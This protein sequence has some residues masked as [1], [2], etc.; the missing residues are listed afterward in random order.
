MQTGRKKLSSGRMLL[1]AMAGFGIGC[2]DF[3]VAV[4][5]LI[6]HRPRR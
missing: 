6:L 5:L 3:I 4:Y 2:V 1:Y